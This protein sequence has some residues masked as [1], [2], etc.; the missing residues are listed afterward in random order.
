ML[1]PSLPGTLEIPGLHPGSDHDDLHHGGPKLSDTKSWE[2][3]NGC[4]FSAMLGCIFRYTM[5]Y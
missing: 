3:L 2:A 4:L 5:I 1:I